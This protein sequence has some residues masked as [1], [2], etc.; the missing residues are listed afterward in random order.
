MISTWHKFISDIQK[1][2]LTQSWRGNRL[3]KFIFGMTK[4]WNAPWVG[5]Y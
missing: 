4:T 1:R 3:V 5:M 2:W